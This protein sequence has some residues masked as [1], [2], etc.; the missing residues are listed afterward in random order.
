MISI[1]SML[2]GVV[3]TLII[4]L[5]VLALLK[6]LEVTPFARD[7]ACEHSDFLTIDDTVN[8]GI[9]INN[10]LAINSAGKLM[11]SR[12]TPLSSGCNPSGEQDVPIDYPQQCS[13]S[14][15]GQNYVYTY[16]SAPLTPSTLGTTGN[17]VGYFYADNLNSTTK[18]AALPTAVYAGPNCKPEG[19]VGGTLLPTR[20]VPVT[21]WIPQSSIVLSM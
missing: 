18:P 1:N 14:F 9:N 15:N 5:A 10:H 12:S 4:V 13:F 16:P 11:W 20:G 21:N 7:T 8:S 6:S 3:V 2:I 19:K 17:A